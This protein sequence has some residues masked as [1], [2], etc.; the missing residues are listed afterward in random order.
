MNNSKL[1]E[2]YFS[3]N[4]SEVQL[5]EFKTLYENN[6]EFKQE[7]DFLIDLKS[8]S[9][10]E[11]DAEFKK[12]LATYESEFSN[13][14]KSLLAKWLKPL[15]AVAALLVIALSINLMFKNEINEDQL[16]KIY[17]E[18]SKNVS[19]PIVRAEDNETIE[20]K[21]FIAYTETNYEKAFSLFEN[22]FKK[23]KNPEL[24]FYEGNALLALG[25]TEEAIKKFEEHISYSD[26]LTNRSHWYLALAYLKSK[27][28]EEAKLELQ[29]LIDSGEN[30]KKVE[31][32]SLLKQ[33]N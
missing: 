1:I 26:E 4:L 15:T 33:L 12:Q 31:A 30:F 29:T 9:E 28:I 13:S 8:V 11:D 21:A 19:V 22:A 3:N 23:T 5:L 25:Q 2:L 18:P 17:F 10:K 16:F 20:S 24:L 14:R 27:N 32:I 7:V 6:L